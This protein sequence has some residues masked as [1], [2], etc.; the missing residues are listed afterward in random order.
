MSGGNSLVD[1]RR[2]NSYGRRGRW[3]IEGKT[4]KLQANDAAIGGDAKGVQK[5][6]MGMRRQITNETEE[7]DR[8][9]DIAIVTSQIDR[10]PYSEI[11]GKGHNPT[12]RFGGTQQPV[13]QCTRKSKATG[14][15]R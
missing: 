14:P 7:S 1:G 4:D 3:T 13:P 5:T 2:S 6:P 12:V 15:R 8:S 10:G 11:H 9:K